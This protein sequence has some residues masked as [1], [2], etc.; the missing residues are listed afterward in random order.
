MLAESCYSA[1]AHEAKFLVD[2]AWAEYRQGRMEKAAV[3]LL[4]EGKSFPE[5]EVLAYDL[6]IVLASL[7]RMTEAGDWLAD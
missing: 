3:I 5:S 2:W 7:D 6:A 1:H 4:H